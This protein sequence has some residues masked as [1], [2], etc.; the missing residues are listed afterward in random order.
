MKTKKP[1][2]IRNDEDW[3]RALDLVD[4]LWGAKAGTPEG[5][6]LDIMLV[7]CEAYQESSHPMSPSD[8]IEV[9][10]YKI[11]ELGISQNRVAQRLGWSSGRLSEVIN[12][13]RGLTLAMVRQLATVLDISPALLVGEE[14]D[15]GTQYSEANVASIVPVVDFRGAVRSGTDRMQ[16]ATLSAVPD[17]YYLPTLSEQVVCGMK[18]VQT[19]TSDSSSPVLYQQVCV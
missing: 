16:A 15:V 14:V 19:V 1:F 8:P 3:D 2:P 10:E 12:R 17:R 11:R 6:T 13:K 4:E 18:G 7:L 5:D 9:I